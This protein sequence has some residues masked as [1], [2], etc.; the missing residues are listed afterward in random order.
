M[1]KLHFISP[2]SLF[3]CHWRWEVF[4]LDKEWTLSW[5]QS[6]RKFQPNAVLMIG[7]VPYACQTLQLE[8]HYA[9]SCA[10]QLLP[11]APSDAHL[12]F[13][14]RIPEGCVSWSG[15]NSPAVFNVL[16]FTLR[17]WWALCSWNSSKHF[18]SGGHALTR[19]IFDGQHF[20][21]HVN[22]VALSL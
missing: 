11:S 12:G 10:G 20:S 4:F 8:K 5:R 21:K 15:R 6:I 9:N 3:H 2:F 14:G 18:Y 13:S 1:M 7:Q 19:F 22:Q 16:L 17:T